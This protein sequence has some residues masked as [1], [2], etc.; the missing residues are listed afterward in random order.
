MLRRFHVCSICFRFITSY[1]KANGE[2]TY[3]EQFLTSVTSDLDPDLVVF[4]G[5]HL[6]EGQ[7]ESLWQEKFS[8]LIKGLKQLPSRTPVHLELA[9]MVQP[10]FIQEL[11]NKVRFFY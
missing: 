10:H 11:V 4:S 3:M 6:L 1:D 2:A 9:S 7:H 5:L 8:T